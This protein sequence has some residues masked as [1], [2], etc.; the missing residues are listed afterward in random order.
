MP[1]TPNR[2]DL[3][4]LGGAGL[5][6]APFL[7]LLDP[8]A[9]RAAELGGN[10]RLLLFF[11]PNGTV[12]NRWRP[13]MSGGS[14]SFPAGSILEPLDRHASRL[15]VMESD[16]NVGDNHEGGMSNML[17]AGGDTSLDQVVADAI[18]GGTKFASL[19]LGAL[20]SAWGGSN[21]TRMCYRNGAFVTPDDDPA[22]VWSRMFGD[23]GDTTG[24]ERRRS[25]LDLTRAD[26][27]KLQARLGAEENARLEMHLDAL[28][29]V[30]KSLSTTG[31][32][33]E[34]G[35]LVAPNA[36]DN[37]AFPDIAKA[38]IDL[39]VQALACGM[40]KVTSVQLSHTVGPVVFTWL[41]ESEGHHSLS[42][43]DDSNQSGID[44][45]VNCERWFAE[46]F[47]YLLDQL[48]ALPDPETGGTMLDT[49]VVLWVQEL[50]DGRMHQC[51]DVPW[52]LAGGDGFFTT[53]RYLQLDTT[54]DAV[55][56]SVANSLGVDIPSFGTG[57]AGPA[58][59]LR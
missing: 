41:G 44:S 50:G 48:E 37:D 12:H 19:E 27:T 1:H 11:T 22:S 49:T 8:A 23:L 33:E 38:Q 39:A 10:Q 6:A 28:N 15:L 14:L 17:T 54:H 13:T 36:S 32:C 29:D 35:V 56:T 5:I 43:I 16:F 24:L 7:R 45:F 4:R 3:L 9:A 55:L 25:I 42:H 40:T 34:P 31:T 59:A 47:A 30:E 20:T 21:Q 51:V 46:Q 2:R 52:V 53:N 57:T 18:G 26:I 58:E